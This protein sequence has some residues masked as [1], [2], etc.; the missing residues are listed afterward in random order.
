MTDV[1]SSAS[2]AAAKTRIAAI[3]A[4]LETMKRR[5][6][7]LREDLDRQRARLEITCACGCGHSYPIHDL[8]AIQTY[9]YELAHGCTDGDNW[10]LGEMQFVCPET[11]ARNRLLFD[12]YDV[13][14]EYRSH[15]D[16]NPAEQFRRMYG[17]LFKE[18]R[19]DQDEESARVVTA[20]NRTVDFNRA[21]YGLVERGAYAKQHGK[22]LDEPAH[23]RAPAP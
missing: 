13:P 12:N 9:W 5:E 2:H 17:K 15:Y 22:N 8:V 7:A 21:T 16:W 10:R 23:A 4:E 6:V 18:L 1:I 20:I 11:G 3:Y 19:E 14:W